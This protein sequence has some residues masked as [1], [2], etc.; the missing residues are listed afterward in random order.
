MVKIAIA[1]GSGQV[2]REIINAIRARERHSIVIL[3]RSD[4][5]TTVGSSGIKWKQVDY[6]DKTALRDTLRGID[7]VL[8]F[9]QLLSD[10]GQKAQKN[11]IDAAIAAGVRRFS[12]SEYGR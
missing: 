2:A 3:T 5:S 7:T 4:T 8:S 10:P 6:E 1:G 9:I 12:P 11:L